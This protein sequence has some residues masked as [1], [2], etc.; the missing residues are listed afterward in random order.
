MRKYNHSNRECPS[1][2]LVSTNNT[3]E[4]KNVF[5]AI[6]LEMTATDYTVCLFLSFIFAIFKYI[7]KLK[8]EGNVTLPPLCN[9][10][11]LCSSLFLFLSFVCIN[12]LSYNLGSFSCTQKQ[13]IFD[14]SD[15]MH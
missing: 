6:F 11:F 4:P 14:L 3:N 12:Q 1:L 13:N 2:P 10:P 15:K 8:N 7:Y 5:F 9:L